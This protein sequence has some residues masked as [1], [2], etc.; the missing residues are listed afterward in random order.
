M[1]AALGPSMIASSQ[2]RGSGTSIRPTPAAVASSGCGG[3]MTGRT[4]N[5]ERE[6]ATS[7]VGAPPL[8]F[9]I[10]APSEESL[11]HPGALPNR[12]MHPNQNMLV[13]DVHDKPPRADS[14]RQSRRLAAR[15]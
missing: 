7:V 4:S 2:A 15:H 11:H 12:F 10:C 5:R 1:I 3:N 14:H 6:L 9:A 13:S 8:E